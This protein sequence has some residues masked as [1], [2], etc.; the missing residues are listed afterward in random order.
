MLLGIS[1]T[2]RLK[3]DG[4]DNEESDEELDAGNA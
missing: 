1:A 3:N 4:S 2:T